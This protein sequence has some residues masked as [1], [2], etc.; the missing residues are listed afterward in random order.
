MILLVNNHYIP[1]F[2]LRHFCIEGKI[3]YYNLS[4]QM[5]ES[6]NTKSVFSEKG[7]YPDE[8]EES[9]CSKIESLFARLLAENISISKHKIILSRNDLFIVKKF[10]LISI[11]RVRDE[12]LEHNAWF[13]ILKRDGIIQDVENF[14]KLFTGDFFSNLNNILECDNEDKM[15]RIISQERN[16]TLYTFI[17][18][19]LFSYLVFV[20]SNNAKEDFVIND[21]GWASYRGPMS[22]K[23]LNAMFNMLQIRYDPFIDMILH[24]SSPQDYAIFPLT[25]NMSILSI[26]PAFKIF[27][28][29]MPYNIIYPDNAPSLSKCLGFGSASVIAPPNNTYS[30][31][32]QKEYV[33]NIKQLTSNDVAFLNSLL[34]S[35]AEQFIGFADVLKVKNSLE[36]SNIKV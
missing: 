1:Q 22:V 23:K 33:Y 21:L 24:M 26:S 34:I 16:F 29:N 7:Y 20:K 12:K 35:Q 8:I 18:D 6:R 11:L 13:Q 30:R 4:T 9:L 19:V 3:Q 15:Q 36:Y 25:H 32:G 14:K 17:R 2:L 27:Q 28:P 10:L 5:V 31:S